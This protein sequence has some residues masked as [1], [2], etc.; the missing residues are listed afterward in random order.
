MKTENHNRLLFRKTVRY[1]M[2]CFVLAW[3][4]A[5]KADHFETGE[6]AAS[7]VEFPVG[8]MGFE[9]FYAVWQYSL[10]RYGSFYGGYLLN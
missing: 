6:N 8:S 7:E 5:L 10:L 3:W 9:V 2:P 4:A 1:V